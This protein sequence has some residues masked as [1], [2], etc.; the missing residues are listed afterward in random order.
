VVILILL[1][2]QK[3]F[4][5]L[6]LNIVKQYKKE[7]AMLMQ[8][9]QSNNDKFYQFLLAPCSLNSLRACSSATLFEQI[10]ETLCGRGF[11]GDRG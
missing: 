1:P 4:K 8:W 6:I 9:Q 11:L 10:K 2:Q 7:M 3:L 5:V